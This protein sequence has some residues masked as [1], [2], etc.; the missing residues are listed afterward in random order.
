LAV[1][2]ASVLAVDVR[3]CDTHRERRQNE[4]S[5]LTTDLSLGM[6]CQAWWNSRRLSAGF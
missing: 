2:V 6:P 1:D 3:R 4:G 5:Q